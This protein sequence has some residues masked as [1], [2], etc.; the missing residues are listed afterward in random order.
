MVAFIKW[1][2]SSVAKIRKYSVVCVVLL[3]LFPSEKQIVSRMMLFLLVRGMSRKELEG[4]LTS[5]KGY[6]VDWILSNQIAPSG[7]G[8]K[9]PTVGRS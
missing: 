7:G 2:S 8:K 1:R 4:L 6:G 3:D 5:T 9:R